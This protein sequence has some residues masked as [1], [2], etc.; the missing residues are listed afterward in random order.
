M[1][2]Y[3]AASAG[4]PGSR[5]CRQCM[6]QAQN[7]LQ[8]APCDRGR[9]E[10]AGS[11]AHTGLLP[12]APHDV[13]SMPCIA[14]HRIL[15]HP[16]QVCLGPMLPKAGC[17][18]EQQGSPPGL[19]IIRALLDGPAPEQERVLFQLDPSRPG[20]CAIASMSPMLRVFRLQEISLQ[21][22]RSRPGL[23]SEAERPQGHVKGGLLRP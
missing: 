23:L 13:V 20:V 18:H 6:M 7:G 21:D 3:H 4:W 12:C 2:G 16:I 9:R 1:R 15:H 19:P 10:Y 8:G 22:C 11:Q 14:L 17:K 5:L